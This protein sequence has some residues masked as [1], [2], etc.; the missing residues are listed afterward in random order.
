MQ[1]PAPTTA[2]QS[3]VRQPPDRWMT[4]ARMTLYQSLLLTERVS[5]APPA[6]LNP[7][8]LLP[9][10]DQAPAHKCEEI[11][12]EETGIRPDLTDQPWP[13]AMTWFTDGSSVVVEDTF[14]GWV[15]AF[16][17][18][19]ETANVVVK[20]ILEEI[21]PRFGIPKVM[22]SD[23]GPAF[24]SQVPHQFEVGDAVLVRRHRAGNLEPRWKG[25]YLV[26]LT[27]PTMVKVEG[28]PTWVHASHV[29]RAYPGVS[30]DEWT[31]EKTNNP[32]KLHL[33]RKSDPKGLQPP[34]S[35]S[36]NVGGTQ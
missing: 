27:K 14:S 16:P 5:F 34:Q 8:S 3:I 33:L 29:K 2:R 35:C 9:E 1:I 4:N 11:L 12:A 10:A 32:F 13:G 20:K 7:A 31:L 15:E 23:N 26:L 28:I 22:G 19:K 21:L 24:V 30:H 36:T 6:I 25:P 18:K 17:T